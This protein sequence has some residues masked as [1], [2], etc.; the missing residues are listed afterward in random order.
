MTSKGVKQAMMSTANSKRVMALAVTTAMA[1]ALLSGCT[2][3]AAP[4]A[5]H[6]ASQAELARASGKHSRAVTHA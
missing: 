3:N 5:A 6:S 2:T 4:S 1:G